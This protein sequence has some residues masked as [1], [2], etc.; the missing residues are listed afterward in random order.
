MTPTS[1]SASDARTLA[2]ST[3]LRSYS[4]TVI[5]ECGPWVLHRRI[6]LQ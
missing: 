4:L 2:T 5:G 1:P 3:D 6:S